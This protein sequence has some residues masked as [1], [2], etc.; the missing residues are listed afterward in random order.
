MRAAL[1][2]LILLLLPLLLLLLLGVLD[3]SPGPPS[4][5][6]RRERMRA[7]WS[8]CDEVGVAVAVAVAVAMG[9]AMVDGVGV[10]RG[11]TLT[12]PLRCTW[13]AWVWSRG[14]MAT[15]TC[16]GMRSCRRVGCVH[17]VEPLQSKVRSVFKIGF[18]NQFYIGFAVF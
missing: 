11:R 8:P 13:T 3:E 10:E 12:L 9:V 5:F 17:S 2:L 6:F 16:G 4:L 15:G 14:F 7:R 18:E 1:L